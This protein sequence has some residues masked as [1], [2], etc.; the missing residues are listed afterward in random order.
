MS[1]K[2]F[3]NLLALNVLSINL[4]SHEKDLIRKVKVPFE[5]HCDIKRYSI[6]KI[7][8]WFFRFNDRGRDICIR[9]TEW[10]PLPPFYPDNDVSTIYLR[11]E[12]DS[13]G[14]GN[15][16]GLLSGGNGVLEGNY[17]IQF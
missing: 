5:A 11:M 10:N 15:F 1:F 3:P 16:T 13:W 12:H 17:M 2:E 8:D 6:P 7:T 9:Y 14:V 4:L